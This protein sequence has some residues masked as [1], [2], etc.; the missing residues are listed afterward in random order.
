MIGHSKGGA[1]AANSVAIN[2]NAIIFNPATVNLSAYEL[3]TST[4]IYQ[5][6]LH[7]LSKE[8]H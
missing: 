6:W 7:M 5:I 2:T 1:E 4:Y 8:M 3:D